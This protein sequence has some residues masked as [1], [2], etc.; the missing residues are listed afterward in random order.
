[1][2][3]ASSRARGALVDTDVN[4]WPAMIDMLTSLLMFFLLI[5]FVQNNVNPA[6]LAAEIARQKQQ[7]FNEL[8]DREFKADVARGDIQITSDV[9]LLQI[10]FGEEIL[11]PSGEYRLQDRGAA[12]L[13]RLA[14][15]VHAVDQ[16]SATPLYDQLQIEGHTDSRRLVRSTYPHDNWELSSA[17]ALEVLRFLT[18]RTWP[19]LDRKTMSA[20]GYADTRPRGGRSAANRRIE[21]RFYFSGREVLPAGQ[22]TPAR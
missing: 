20:N 17:R 16:S 14:R 7:K 19:P 12:I 9:N 5:H 22:G 3:G 1:M 11:F 8:F 2:H 18:E 15:V 10:T 13:R 6:G 21:I 4:F